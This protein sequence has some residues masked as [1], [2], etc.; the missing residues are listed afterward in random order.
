MRRHV[1]PPLDRGEAAIQDVEF[2]CRLRAFLREIS[3]LLIVC[4]YPGDKFFGAAALTGFL[5][6][7]SPKA[8]RS[9]QFAGT[10]STTQSS[11][12]E[13]S[14]GLTTAPARG[15]IMR[16]SMP[17]HCG[18]A[19][20]STGRDDRAAECSSA[21][22][23]S[24]APAA[25]AGP[26]SSTNLYVRL[27]LKTVIPLRRHHSVICHGKL[28]IPSYCHLSIILRSSHCNTLSLRRA[29]R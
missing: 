28:R 22:I 15:D 8:V 18:T 21:V 25:P 24:R 29:M 20:S 14:G 10:P 27:G 1:Y 7:C 9:P 5:L 2:T 17:G 6:P 16:W 11:L 26:S 3:G 13:L 19:G 12:S 4:D 23:T